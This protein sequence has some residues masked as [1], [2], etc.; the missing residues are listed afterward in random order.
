MKH[1]FCVGTLFLV[2]VAVGIGCGDSEPENA[3]ENFVSQPEAKP[4]PQPKD[5]LKATCMLKGKRKADVA[6]EYGDQGFNFSFMGQPVPPSGTALYSVT[7]FDKT[8]EYGVQ[9]GVK[10]LD[11]KQTAYFIFSFDTNE[12]V[13]LDGTAVVEGNAVSG[14]FPAKDPGQLLDAGP[15]SWSAV[16]NVEGNDVGECPGDAKSLPFPG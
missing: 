12:Q 13:N 8:G 10:Y 16:F 2:L 14:N 9:L 6:L 7:V 1:R 11:G 3:S 15:A 4:V 5:N